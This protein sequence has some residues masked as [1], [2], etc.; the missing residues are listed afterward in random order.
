MRANEVFYFD[1]DFVEVSKDERIADRC[2]NC[3]CDIMIGEEYYDVN[4]TIICEECIDE[5]KKTARSKE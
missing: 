2:E 5:Y 1:D 3:H 4:G